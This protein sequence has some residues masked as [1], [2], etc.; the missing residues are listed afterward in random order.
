LQVECGVVIVGSG[1]GG[2]TVAAELTD[3][4][5]N[6][7]NNGCPTGAKRSMLVTSVP[8][9]LAGGARLFAD[10]RVDKITHS[11]RTITGLSGRFIRPGGKPGPGL[12]VRAHAVVVAGGA[13]QTPAP[14]GDDHRPGHAQRAAADRAAS[15]VRHLTRIFNVFFRRVEPPVSG[16]RRHN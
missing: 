11:E 13:I 6:N 9:A 15:R 5:T 12:T 4:G 8:R 16:G 7:C 10:C 14:D 3:A 1:A 2:A